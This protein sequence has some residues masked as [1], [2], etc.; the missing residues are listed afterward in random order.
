MR[1]V[2]IRARA[3][4]GQVSDM[5]GVELCEALQG[6]PGTRCAV[7]MIVGV[8]LLEYDCWSIIVGMEYDI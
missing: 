5:Q 2:R 3:V 1:S 4:G 8:W 7:L 6:P